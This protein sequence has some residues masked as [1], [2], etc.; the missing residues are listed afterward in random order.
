[1]KPANE[2]NIGLIVTEN[3]QTASVFRSFGIDFCCKGHQTLEVAC[4][5]KGIQLQTVEDE[6]KKVSTK[7]SGPGQG[8]KDWSLDLLA[9]YIEKKHHRYVRGKIPELQS[10]LE[11]LCKVH[12][13]NHPELYEIKKTFDQTAVDLQSHMLKEENIIFPYIRKM[14][15]ALENQKNH[16]VMPSF[17]T[18]ENPINMMKKEHDTEGA[19]FRQIYNLTN[20]YKAP[21]DGCTTY[22]VAFSMLEDF[23]KD[24]HQHIHLENN[25]LF[26]NAIQMETKFHRT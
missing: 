19:R 16:I 11:K 24:L 14:E 21:S 3:Y 10:Y 20:G 6:L 17:V 12:G 8:F 7:N 2:K 26:P 22:R 13:Q 4:R 15:S 23:E 18:I 25:I 1:M 5:K 9:D